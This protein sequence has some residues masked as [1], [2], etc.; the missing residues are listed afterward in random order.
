MGFAVDWTA[1]EP[2]PHCDSI[3][4]HHAEPCLRRYSETAGPVRER[5][6]AGGG[7]AILK[8]QYFLLRT[9]ITEDG[10]YDYRG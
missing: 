6:P 5:L 1:T 2:Q 8:V 7:C 4:L 3:P 9:R 10:E